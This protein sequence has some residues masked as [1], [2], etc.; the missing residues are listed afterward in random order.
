MTAELVDPVVDAI[1]WN[2]DYDF[3]I[4]DIST[5]VI[6]LASTLLD[7]LGTPAEA[8]ELDRVKDIGTF[9]PQAYDL[10][11]LAGAA[12]DIDAEEA[13]LV[14]ALEIDPNYAEALVS[15]AHLF[16]RRAVSQ[17]F[18]DMSQPYQWLKE[19]RALS[20]RALVLDSGVYSA[21]DLL[22]GVC[23][24]LEV[25]YSEPC[26]P[27]DIDRLTEEECEVRGNS[28]EGW[29]CRHR[30]LGFRNEDGTEALK[31]WLELEP[32]SAD[33]NMQ[34]MGELWFTERRFNEALAV[35]D[36]LRALEPGDKRVFGLVSNGLRKE[37]RLD[38][39]LA[40]RYGV[41]SDKIPDN[42]WGLAR[43]STD[44]MALG[45]FEQAAGI[46]LQVWDIRRASATHFMPL[47]WTRMGEPKRA[48]EAME[49][50]T[51]TTYAASASPTELLELAG[52]YL[53]TLRNYKR[54]GEI[55][56]EVLADYEL[57]ELC[58]GADDCMIKLPLWL[59]HYKHAIGQ[60]KEATVWLEMAEK[61][62]AQT[63]DIDDHLDVLLR[64]AQGRHKEAVDLLRDGIFA[65]HTTNG[66]GPDLVFPIYYLED[67]AMLDPLRGMPEFQQLL[68][69]YN[70]QLEPF[71]TRVL[72][73]EQSKD[74]AALRQN[75]YQWAEDKAK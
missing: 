8:A 65:W 49:W 74:W 52:F 60:E 1:L 14:Q 10:F 26:P 50:L 39:M 53:D 32:T 7:I 63:Q 71:R 20:Q 27:G 34:Y 48:A 44:Y 75:T 66:G 16:L 33:A 68:D 23:Q 37:G 59:R 25:Y 19:T 13:L 30:L 64:V 43:L 28:A 45:L 42:P 69:D 12:G 15:H 40:W 5:V 51:E 57:S 36:T 61:A 58:E 11:L 67:N 4:E 21:R 17:E 70:A 72:E 31:H 41:F 3:A 6:E 29:A 54:A 38:E 2:H 55:Y 73:A 47:L 22:A 62:A 24:M 18:E 35:F 9:S 56:N 46:G